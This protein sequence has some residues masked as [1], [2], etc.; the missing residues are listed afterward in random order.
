MNTGLPPDARSPAEPPRAHGGGAPPAAASLGGSLVVR[1]CALTDVGQTRE[2]NEDSYLVAELAHA[3]PLAFADDPSPHG[4]GSAAG[5]RAAG[6]AAALPDRSPV[7]HERAPADDGMLFIVADGLGGAAAGEVASR[8]AVRAVFEAMR[9]RAPDAAADADA[10]ATALRD[11]AHAANAAIHQYAARHPEFRGMGTTLTAAAVRGDALFVAQ[12]GDS[13]AYL[14]RDGV[15]RQLTKD[16]SLMQKLIEAG[17]ITPEQAETS[18]RRNIILQAL[19]PEAS[20]K[21]DLTHQRL[22]QGDLLLLCS[23]GLSGQV[24]A[25]ALAAAAEGAADLAALCTT[26]VGLANDS[27]GPDNITVVAARFDGPALERAGGDDDDH[28]GHRAFTVA[29][30]TPD[31]PIAPILPAATFAPAATPALPP[32]AS[33]GAAPGVPPAELAERRDRARVV[34]VLLAAVAALL[35]TVLLWRFLSA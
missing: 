5:G 23:D 16:Q 20:V 14:V 26:L 31:A 32:T 9:A 10:F 1:V 33:R 11:A 15:A 24:R 34:Y 13:R 29:A 7:V 3:E 30:P 8:M 27:G 18:L 12:V 4:D 17:E 25:S 19:G 28:V 22:R 6:A 21:V 2:H 35:A